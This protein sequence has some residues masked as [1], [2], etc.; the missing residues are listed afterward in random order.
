MRKI[1]WKILCIVIIF[2]VIVMGLMGPVPHL[3]IINESIRNTYFH[4][5]LWL[6]MTTLLF[7]SMI[8]SIRYLNKGR[9]G[10]DDIAS[11]LA[12]SAIFF[13]ILGCLTGSIWANYTWGD[14]WPNDPKLNGAAVGILIYLAYLL[15]RS[16]FEDEQRKARISSVYNIFAFAV[17]IPIIYILPRLTDSLH[18]GSGG[19]S[20]FGSYDFNSDIRKVFYPAIIGYILLGLW[21]AELRIRIKVINRV[22]DEALVTSAK[23]S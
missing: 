4:V 23:V 14:P 21:L 15:L 16:S 7:A 3:A 6:A 22:R 8:F 11:E 1:W 13:G 12:K 2:Y 19:N 9:I 17:F 20:T 5:A 10:D 18:P